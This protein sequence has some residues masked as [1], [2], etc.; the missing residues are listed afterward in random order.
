MSHESENMGDESHLDSVKLVAILEFRNMT[1]PT[2]IDRTGE[3]YK[4]NRRTT[5]AVK[6]ETGEIAMSYT[7]LIARVNFGERWDAVV[8]DV[9][10]GRA[11]SMPAV[12][13]ARVR[14]E[15]AFCCHF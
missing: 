3:T 15:R 7:P 10:R 2:V 5:V 11:G 4:N 9:R 8:P 6:H 12:L 1:V 14:D 13:Q